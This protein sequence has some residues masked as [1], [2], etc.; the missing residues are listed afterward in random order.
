MT[1]RQAQIDGV[2]KWAETLTS[3]PEDWKYPALKLSIQY[4]LAC[5]V[6]PPALNPLPEDGTLGIVLDENNQVLDPPKAFDSSGYSLFDEQAE[7]ELLEQLSRLPA[8]T[9]PT[10]Y[11]L[12]FEV[13][14]DCPSS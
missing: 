10:A 14:L 5:E 8:R 9:K 7:A 13:V 12:E 3:S 6:D 4:Q 2:S 11:M 1:P